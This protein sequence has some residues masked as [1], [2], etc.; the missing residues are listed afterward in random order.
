M[1]NYVKVT[2][3]TVSIMAMNTPN[4]NELY[5]SRGENHQKLSP[6]VATSIFNAML[7]FKK[8]G[9]DLHHFGVVVERNDEGKILV[10]FNAKRAPGEKILGGRTS[11]GQSMTYY[12]SPSDG[13]ILKE[14][15]QR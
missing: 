15:R 3:L 12:A 4:A 13:S 14:Q 7:E 2:I 9:Q 6:I 1:I 5:S 8:T 10:S 11:F